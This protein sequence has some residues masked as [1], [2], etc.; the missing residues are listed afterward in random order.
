MIITNNFQSQVWVIAG[1]NGAGKTSF[2]NKYLRGK[3][4][5]INPDDIALQNNL[6][7]VNAGKE[8][9]NLRQKFLNQNISFA[10]ETT[11][12]GINEIKF[13]Q[14]CKNANYKINFVYIYLDSQYL[15]Y[16]RVQQ[17]IE[18]N[19]HS[20][21]SQDIQRRYLRSINNFKNI[22][23][24]SHRTWILDNSGIKTKM[25]YS[26]IN[27]QVK[28]ISNNIPAKIITVFNLNEK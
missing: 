19:G 2:A 24:I 27:N 8:A 13:I 7:A 28:F 15:S 20:I 14:Q 10:I 22:E 1:V 17:R 3:I 6:Q 4:A 9:L 16:A 21:P 26:S 12:S 5:I 25:I 23:Q 11:L 18:N